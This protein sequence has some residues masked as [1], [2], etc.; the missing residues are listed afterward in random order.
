MHLDSFYRE[1]MGAYF[2]VGFFLNKP[3]MK[4]IMNVSRYPK[5]KCRLHRRTFMIDLLELTKV[6]SLA[7]QPDN[8]DPEAQ[9]PYYLTYNKWL[10]IERYNNKKQYRK[11][12]FHLMRYINGQLNLQ[13]LREKTIVTLYDNRIPLE[14]T[15]EFNQERMKYQLMHEQNLKIQKFVAKKQSRMFLQMLVKFQRK[16]RNR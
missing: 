4:L 9:D 14:E 7:N 15:K 2:E 5:K 12:Y 6:Y 10:D 11:V 8:K 13:L 3:Q 1:S 16:V